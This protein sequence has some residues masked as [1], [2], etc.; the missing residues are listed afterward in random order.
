[1]AGTK[2]AKVLMVDDRSENLLALEAILQSL[3]HQLVR[4]GSGPEALKR[5]LTDS[6][7]VVLMDVQM[8]GMDGF[9]TAEHIKRREKTR[10]TPIV[11]MTAGTAEAHSTRRGYA[12]G[13]VDYLAKPFDPWVLRAKVAFF[14]EL[15]LREAE[16]ARREEAL[17]LEVEALRRRIAELERGGGAG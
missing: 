6:F 11:F 17:A 16:A 15:H 13:A 12:A 7:A 3:G 8:P 1:M 2:L 5:L 14:I 9:E 4:A 10:N